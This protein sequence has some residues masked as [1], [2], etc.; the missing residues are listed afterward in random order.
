VLGGTGSSG[1]AVIEA[2]LSRGHQALALARSAS[3]AARVNAV[4]ARAL[5]GD[6]RDPGAWIAAA[7]RVDA[8]ILA[9]G[10]FTPDAA[11]VE[12]ALLKALLYRLKSAAAGKTLIYTGGCWLYGAT[13]DRVAT[14][15][16]PLQPPAAWRWSVDQLQRVLGASDVRGIVIHP[17]MIYERDG[18]VSASFR[19]DIAGIGRVRIVGHQGVRWPL[20]HRRDIG[21]LYALA[22][23]RGAPANSYNGS[24][25]DS[26]AVGVIARAMAQR[27]G[28][29]LPP[30][31]R[32]ADEVAAE[33][34]EWARS[35]AIDQRMSGVRRGSA[36]LPQG[37]FSGALALSG[38][39]RS[40]GCRMLN[41]IPSA[42][43]KS[44]GT[45]PVG[46]APTYLLSLVTVTAPSAWWIS[47]WTAVSPVKV[48]TLVL[49]LTWPP[50]L[51]SV[52]SVYTVPRWV[53]LMIL[54]G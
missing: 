13:G 54:Q 27:A 38:S 12:C 44:P 4:G 43:T 37:F 31:I 50:K 18:G 52:R 40:S 5:P 1:A 2:L 25:I 21:T 11:A 46:Q 34:G 24:A 49:F 36:P 48:V 29:A 9:A 23:E 20:V 33:L 14:E 42:P 6:M 45:M 41:F 32:P 28:L 16:S 3:A 53:R 10:D 47:V 51:H 8:A 17:A 22:L 19:E 26:I 7:D 35:Y 39:L 15:D 30:L